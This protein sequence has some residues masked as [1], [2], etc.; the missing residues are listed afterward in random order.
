MRN[1]R[2]AEGVRITPLGARWRGSAYPAGRRAGP[3]LALALGLLLGSPVTAQDSPPAPEGAAA[4]PDLDS[5]L[6]LPESGTYE[7]DVR[8]G[9]TPGE[10]REL[11]SE[12][13]ERL[14][15]ERAEL[16]EAKAELDETASKKD[17]WKMAPPIP[18]VEV[19]DTESPL[20]FQLRQRIRRH[21]AEIDRLERNQRELEIEASLAGVPEDWRT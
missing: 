16:A 12:I 4:T 6:K 13:R 21:R 3:A 9:R 1:E 5:L 19:Q 17:A 18:G 15:K 7:V 2:A 8:G 10:W 11:F 20:D 14:E